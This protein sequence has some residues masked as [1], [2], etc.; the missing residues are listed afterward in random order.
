MRAVAVLSVLL[1]HAHFGVSGGYVGVDVFFVISGFLITTLLF[2]ERAATGRIALGNFYARRIRRLLPAATLVLL[3][4]V[5]LTHQMLDPVRAHRTAIDARWSGAF[6][7][8]IHFAIDGGDYLRSTL[9][10]S[11]LQHWWSL[12]VE[13]QFYLLW[14][15]LLGLVWWRARRLALRAF[16]VCGALAVAS[17]FVGLHLTTNRPSWGYYAPW[18][19]GWELAF[20]AMCAFVWPHRH[21]LP[22]R[23]LAGWVGA[24]MVAYGALVFDRTTAFP[25]TAALVPVA[26][27]ALLILS[28]GAAH[29]PGRTLCLAPLQWI[30]G[31]SYAIYLWHWPLLTILAARIEH[32]S[33]W[34]RA[35]MLALSV[36]L[37]A[38]SHRLLETPLR[39]LPLLSR[40][41][42]RSLAAGV[43]L[44]GLVLGA[45]TLAAE[46]TAEVRI[47]TGYIAPVTNTAEP[48]TSTTEPTESAPTA[49]TDTTPD[50][51]PDTTA[52]PAWDDVLATKIADELQPLIAASAVQ[53]LTPDNLTPSIA[54]QP[55]DRTLP[56]ADGCLVNYFTSD[57]GPCEY[58]DL[59]SETT[60]ALFGDSHVDQ[61][62]PAA[63]AAAVRNHWKLIIVTKKA[64]PAADVQVTLDNG[65]P[66]REC[67][68]WRPKA[69]ARL[70]EASPSLVIIT[71]WRR[72]YRLNDRGTERELTDDQWRD[73][74]SRSI[75]LLQQGDVPVLLLADTPYAREHMDSCIAGNLRHLSRCHLS[76]AE[77]IN[78]RENEI[79]R[80]L[81]ESMGVSF[82]D[83]GDWFCAGD[84][85]PVVI[86]N[87]AVYLDTNHLTNTYGLFLTPYVELLVKHHL[88]LADQ[89]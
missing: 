70:L 1:Y 20:G 78:G 59:T 27:T 64:C 44:V 13:E 14:P 69:I 3:A 30:G 16:V 35:A 31:R 21:R 83:T 61:W 7:A 32:P 85:C 37:A 53:E 79:E 67:D 74:L 77:A 71:Q 84:V 52:L 76:R 15:G 47:S 60:I 82:Y 62:F 75:A 22:G 39:H 43:V 48:A 29:S 81:A 33:P 45:A 51:T 46:A 41:T 18:S 49:S 58:G 25:G 40:A 68:E 8:N 6:L 5:L 10:P 19:R 17:F 57:F 89:R 66:Y 56:Y 86:G 38:L 87:T 12:A 11:P 9:P 54:A 65:T 42:W 23:A 55:N 28:I 50:T 80:S 24:A 73:G 63:E 36:V 88:Q 4:T 2:D 34:W 72:K 26:G